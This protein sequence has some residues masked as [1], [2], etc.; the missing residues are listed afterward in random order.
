MLDKMLVEKESRIGRKE[1]MW[2]RSKSGRLLIMSLL[3]SALV[4]AFCRTGDRQ[5]SLLIF[6]LST[7]SI[8]CLSLLSLASVSILCRLMLSE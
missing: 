3:S 2:V 5:V 7:L 4:W 6:I 1:R 8:L